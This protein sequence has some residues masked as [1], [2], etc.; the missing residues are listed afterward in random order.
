MLVRLA[1]SVFEL[2]GCTAFAL[3][4][5]LGLLI[6][7]CADVSVALERVAGLIALAGIPILAAGLLVHR[8]LTE[9]SE[10]G[11]FRTAG[12]G[13]ALL[14]MA[15]MLLAGVLAW[16][17]PMALLIVCALDF[18]VLSVVAF[19]FQLPAAHA[20]ALPCV[21]VA[22]LTSFHLI[23]GKIEAAD[24]PGLVRAAFS[25]QSG[26]ALVMLAVV[27]GCG[28]EWLA[29]RHAREHAMFYAVGAAVTAGLSLAI[30]TGR[31]VTDPG[32]ATL[33]YAVYGVGFLAANARWRRP[34]TTSLGLVLLIGATLWSL[35]WSS[36][37]LT[38]AWGLVLAAESLL[39]SVLTLL[40]DRYRVA[41]LE[42]DNPEGPVPLIDLYR[43]PLPVTA[44]ASGALALILSLASPD[45][46]ASAFYPW[47]AAVLG[48]S[49]LVLA[50]VYQQA[51]LT[52]VGSGLLLGGFGLEFRYGLADL[53]L[54]HPWA[55]ALLVHAS[56][57]LLASLLVRVRWRWQPDSPEDAPATILR[58]LFVEPLRGSALVSSLVAVPLLTLP[59]L[60]SPGDAQLTSLAGFTTWL[61]VLWL[62]IAS[63]ERWPGLFTAFQ[64]ALSV[65]GLYGVTAW[66]EAQGLIRVYPDD[67]F[68]PRSLQAYGVGLGCLALLWVLARVGLHSKKRAAAL[69]EPDWP[70]FDRV[71]LG[72]LVIGQAILA[73]WGIWPDVLRELT[74][75]GM[76]PP[77]GAWHAGRSAAYG[78]GGWALLA[79]LAVVLVT[80]LWE[81]YQTGA[82]LGL[83]VIAFTAPVLAAGQFAPE[84][85]AAS[86]LR[87]GLAGAFLVCSVPFWLRD[88]IGRVARRLA[89]PLDPDVPLVALARPLLLCGSALPVIG[90]TTVVAMI[91]FSGQP[92]AGPTPN[93]MFAHMGS[94]LSN[95]MPM[96]V[97]SL[98]LVGH[99][100]RERSAGYAFSAG[101]VA[102]VTLMGGY[103][104]HVVHGGQLEEAEWVRLVQIGALGAAAWAIGWLVTRPWTSAWRER[105]ETPL[106]RPLMT[107]QL[108]MAAAGNAFLLTVGVWLLIIP[109]GTGM[110]RLGD[111]WYGVPR[112]WTTEAGSALGWLALGLTI[113]A[114]VLRNW[115]H[116]SLLSPLPLGW[117]G[118]LL[119]GLLACSIERGAAGWGYRALMVGWAG[120]ALAW[121]LLA[122]WQQRIS[123]DREEHKPSQ[124]LSDAAALFVSCAGLLAVMLGLNAA[125]VHHDRLWAAAA[126]ALASPAGA[127]M[128]VQRRREHWAFTA[129]LG[130]NLAASLI[131]WHYHTPASF[132]GWWAHLLQANTIATAAGAL[133]WLAMRRH[134]YEQPE[135]SISGGPLLAAQVTLGIVGNALLLG[136]PLVLLVVYPPLA[137][138]L[139]QFGEAWGWLALLLAFTASLWYCDQIAPPKRAHIVVIFGLALGVLAACAVG[140]FDTG[141]WLSFHVLTAIWC[142]TGLLTLAAGWV[143]TAFRLAGSADASDE[144][145]ATLERIAEFFPADLIP[146][147]ISAIGLL[148]VGLALRGVDDP[149]PPYASAA[150]TLTVSTLFGGLALWSCRQKYVYASGLLINLVGI[151]IWLPRHDGTLISLVSINVICLAIASAFWSTVEWALRG[152]GLG[153]NLRGRGLPFC[154]LSAIV[155]LGLLIVLVLGYAVSGGNSN[156]EQAWT[157]AALELTA[158]AL[159]LTFWDA[160]AR[161]TL[162]G[163]YSVGLLTVGMIVLSYGPLDPSW[164]LHLLGTYF[165]VYVLLATVL[166]RAT[167][168]GSKLWQ[169]LRIPA[170]ERG[171]PEEWF[172]STQILVSVCV[173]GMSV[174]MALRFPT[175]GA[176]LVGPVCVG[177]LLPAGVVLTSIVRRAAVGPEPTFPNV[178]RLTLRDGLAYGTLGLG[179]LAAAELGW[180]LLEPSERILS[181]YHSLTLMVALA[182]M[183]PIYGIGLSRLLSASNP[184]AEVGRKLGP[185]LGALAT[186][187]LV[188]VLL[189]EGASYNALLKRTPMATPA[190]LIMIAAL[191][192]LMVA[193]ISFAVVPGRDPFGLTERGRMLYIYA[194]ELLLVFL[195][196]HLKLTRPEW[197]GTFGAKYWTFLIMGLAFVGVGLGE[198][199]H[200]RGLYVLSE[201]LQRTGVFLPL[202]PLLAFWTRRLAPAEWIASVGRSA[203]AMRPL[204]D[205]IDPT[206]GTRI[207][208]NQ[209]AILWWLAAALLTFLA[210]LKRSYRYSL[211]AALAANFG[212]WSL[213]YHYADIGL[214]FMVHPQLWLIPLAL[215]ALAAEYLN[216]NRL[217]PQ[218]SGT[219]RYLSL[220][221][222]YISSTADMFIAG[223]G[224][225]VYLPLALAVLSVAGVLSGILL[226]VRAFLFL[227]VTFLF[228]VV[229]TMIWHAAVGRQQ[230]W[231]WWVSGI[232]LGGGIIALFALFEKRRNEVLQLV[233]DLKSWK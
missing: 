86:A 32:R 157:W 53:S 141:D 7:R 80:A 117:L 106:A 202:L 134:I 169:S 42:T 142:M 190:V 85:A 177:L 115:G 225:S 66:L 133:L 191:L 149:Y 54:P 2:L 145:R 88:G 172:A 211:L 110:V 71:V 216:R 122:G 161:F 206:I 45:F 1:R 209:Y 13:V 198:F 98:A 108:G 147:W 207:G 12:T 189:Q 89:I 49:A 69:L 154:H 109:M 132:D 111:A 65:A 47:T 44:L 101:L 29:R 162:A 60:V 232:L 150:A 43:E 107:V 129:G 130:I 10:H 179:V 231:I 200:R 194:C 229:F 193:S 63:V 16:P 84:L 230:Y 120:Y 220:L 3:A 143:G 218:Q 213:L 135:L 185:R 75:P 61:A 125:F 62:V 24:G 15:V 214:A 72:G 124:E 128:A 19:R 105:T 148:I 168:M 59:V 131:V 136:W 183:T 158:L 91:G 113:A 87:W 175:L 215:I 25:A 180:A 182:I 166:R 140:P 159:V 127:L 70:A 222:I 31:G 14:G 196:L 224:E 38:P 165:A 77:S 119:V 90:L 118:L 100:L 212:W 138:G 223:L 233:D 228:L 9:E 137:S 22:Y 160:D 104:L 187:M 173:L 58:H 26:A 226:R 221:V 73:I 144:G 208:F 6:Y 205:Y 79:T 35:W 103:A 46:P 116:R 192:V 156:L 139:G 51:L 210:V 123:S 153:L 99:A 184:W 167:P 41:R 176:R 151:L 17:Q 20:A 195:F 97:V 28:A 5:A 23:A 197:F 94:I 92:L 186:V 121:S 203:P 163:L 164:S 93:S 126:I 74:P 171:W 181:L 201:P 18:A 48:A 146:R 199:F 76:L 37:V 57:M 34:A 33:V 50:W 82:V 227:G 36:P 155:A 83:Q 39:L 8:G 188:V 55:I 40:L 112:A 178:R 204:L 78:A 114:V 217:T 27:L 96:A 68:A 67:V 4:V 95:L 11:A 102:N 170:R 219:L 174:W 52:W 64:A 30:V 152:S 21:L 81:R 56:F